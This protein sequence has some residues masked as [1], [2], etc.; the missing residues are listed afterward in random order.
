MA[1]MLEHEQCSL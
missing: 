1:Q